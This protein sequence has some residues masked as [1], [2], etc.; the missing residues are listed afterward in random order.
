[1][2]KFTQPL[3]VVPDSGFQMFFFPMMAEK[4]GGVEGEPTLESWRRVD[5]GAEKS[6]LYDLITENRKIAGWDADWVAEL[7]AHEKLGWKE[8]GVKDTPYVRHRLGACWID[9]KTSLLGVWLAIETNL[10]DKERG[11]YYHTHSYNAQKDSELG[12]RKPYAAESMQSLREPRKFEVEFGK[13]AKRKVEFSVKWAALSTEDIDVDLILDFGNS[14][15]CALVLERQKSAGAIGSSDRFAEI[16]RPLPLRLPFFSDSQAFNVEDSMVSS[17]FVLKT[18]EFR[19]FDFD[20]GG[21]S[22]NRKA[23]VSAIKQGYQ[24]LAKGWKFWAPTQDVPTLVEYR[25][26][27]VFTKLSPVCFGEEVSEMVKGRSKLGTQY[28]KRLHQG[29][30]M[31]QSSAKRF[32]WDDQKLD[33]AKHG[34]TWSMMPH[35]GHEAFKQDD[36][37]EKIPL[38]GLMLRFQ[39]E[40][41]LAWRFDRPPNRWGVDQHG[42]AGRRLSAPPVAPSKPAYPRRNTLTWSILAIMETAQRYINSPNWTAGGQATRRRRIR[43]VVGTYPSGWSSTELDAYRAKWQEALNIFSLTQYPQGAAPV[44]LEMNLDESV[45]SQLPLLYSCIKSFTNENR[46][47]NWIQLNGVERKGGKMPAIRVMNLDIGGG[48]TD[49][50]VV[51]YVDEEKGVDVDLRATVKFRDSYGESGDVLLKLIIEQ[52]IIKKLAEDGQASVDSQ[53][54][55]AR[56][57]EIFEEVGVD[58]EGSTRQGGTQHQQAMRTTQRIRWHV[59]VLIPLAIALL[60]RR[61]QDEQSPEIQFSPVDAD[62]DSHIWTKFQ[63]AFA[64]TREDSATLVFKADELDKL[65]VR[66]FGLLIKRLAAVVASFDVHMIFVCG[67]PSEQPAIRELVERLLPIP[68]ERIHFASGFRSGTWYPFRRRIRLKPGNAEAPVKDVMES[69]DNER[70]DDAKTVTCVGAALARAIDSGLIPGWRLKF[71][72]QP[73]LS[74]HWGE[75]TYDPEH[76]IPRAFMNKVLFPAGAAQSSEVALGLGENRWIGRKMFESDAQRP[77][78]VY[79]L[80]WTGKE[81]DRP[82]KVRVAFRRVAATAEC[83]DALELVSAKDLEGKVDLT[84]QVRLRLEPVSEVSWLDTGRLQLGR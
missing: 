7:S 54:T 78:P 41:G 37:V 2:Y 12:D 28:E 62:I 6:S 75:L 83:A 66:H 68:L 8:H 61:A 67:K 23:L 45:A 38:A 27:N 9:D 32:F 60:R 69:D 20:A 76:G 33:T 4:D 42:E 51:E 34:D 35:F 21:S 55:R 25:I 80:R 79:K 52:I 44:R 13:N 22:T 56:F 18:P 84:D 36:N 82:D 57:R 5:D 17:R 53:L 72:P 65:I 64:I 71:S 14:R 29:Q 46:G 43:T 77:E 10:G 58:S 47:E 15:T 50:S 70:I 26:P 81:G 16:C 63:Q 39:P 1:M 30:L 24:P 59:A 74:N 73:G 40:D 31:Q 3:F 48:T 49:V 19:D 11:W